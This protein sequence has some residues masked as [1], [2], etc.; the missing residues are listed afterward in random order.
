MK[1]SSFC[2]RDRFKT[3][4]VARCLKDRVKQR[5]DCLAE[6]CSVPAHLLSSVPGVLGFS[7]HR[8]HTK[9]KPSDF[10]LV[11]KSSSAMKRRKPFRC[12]CRFLSCADYMRTAP[13]VSIFEP[14]SARKAEVEEMKSS[15]LYMQWRTSLPQ[16]VAEHDRLLKTI[17]PSACRGLSTWHIERSIC[18]IELVLD[19][20]MVDRATA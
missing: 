5:S 12:H 6:G 16:P 15:N 9:A 3:Q 4:S 13:M 20:S 1:T 8:R 14:E 19:C 18:Y 7:T 2:I 11:S 10:A 17:R